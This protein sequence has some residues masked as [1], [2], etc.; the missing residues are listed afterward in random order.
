MIQHLESTGI[1]E[2]GVTG[3]YIRTAGDELL[4]LLL[5]GYL[6]KQAHNEQR[7]TLV[8]A[9]DDQP[10]NHVR[11]DTCRTLTS[12]FGSVKVTRPGYSQRQ[13]SS[14]FPLDSLLNLYTDQYTDGVRKRIVR[15]LADRSY[16]RA[17]E[18]HRETCADIVGKR[19][20]IQLAEDSARGFVSFYEQRA[21][22]NEQTDDLLILSID[23]KGVVMLPD[24]LRVCTRKP[25]EKSQRK[26]QTRL[27]A[28][29]KKDN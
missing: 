18:R 22:Q 9:S 12:L 21:V 25:A 26:L 6:D 2:H 28:G 16:D 11:K 10:R 1:Q 15:D 3:E 14:L 13:Q 5:Q 19:Q 24:G 27:S 29:E 7:V 23:G 20:A 4:R 8:T 17:V